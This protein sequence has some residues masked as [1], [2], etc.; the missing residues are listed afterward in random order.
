MTAMQSNPLIDRLFTLLG[1]PERTENIAG[2]IAEYRRALDGYGSTVLQKAADHLVRNC[3]KAWPSLKAC[4]EACN[5]TAEQAALAAQANSTGRPKAQLPW[6]I[7]AERARDWARDYCRT[8]ALGQEAFRKG[9]GRALFDYVRSYARECYR[10]GREPKANAY[11]PPQ[12]VLD[13]YDRYARDPAGLVLLDR[14]SLL[15]EP[16]P[17]RTAAGKLVPPSQLFQSP[18]A[19]AVSEDQFQIDQELGA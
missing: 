7:E 15:G 2:F 5:D 13:Y 19:P 12:D 8:T 4:V 1:A 10:A 16:M 14:H 6:E 17:T 9:Y 11:R 3:G 18:L